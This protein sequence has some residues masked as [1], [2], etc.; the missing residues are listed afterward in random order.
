MPRAGNDRV[1]VAGW[2][3]RFACLHFE[4]R[5]PLFKRRIGNFDR[6]IQKKTNCRLGKVSAGGLPCLANVYLVPASTSPF[7]EE[8]GRSLVY[9]GPTIPIFHL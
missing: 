1:S 5:W 6:P 3:C 2:S 8:K 9:L 4:G 7:L